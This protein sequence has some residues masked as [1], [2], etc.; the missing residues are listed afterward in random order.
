MVW[1][2]LSR[3]L[4][5]V[6]VLVSALLSSLKVDLSLQN[7]HWPR[8]AQPNSRLHS[9]VLCFCPHGGEWAIGMGSQGD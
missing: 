2:R 1:A 4:G 9:S 6:H 7:G 8:Q 3:G 5:K